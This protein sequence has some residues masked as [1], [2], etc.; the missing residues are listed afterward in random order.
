MLSEKY[1]EKKNEQELL[2]KIKS[3]LKKGPVPIAVDAV[4]NTKA[5]LRKPS[6]KIAIRRRWK[7]LAREEFE[8]SKFDTLRL[9]MPSPGSRQNG[10]D[11]E[12]DIV[13]PVYAPPRLENHEFTDNMM[14]IGLYMMLKQKKDDYYLMLLHSFK[15]DVRNFPEDMKLMLS[16]KYWKRNGMPKKGK[17]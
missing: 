5:D 11:L 8:K 13:V 16:G 7:K 2:L 6:I 3:E 15:L 12:E 17:K 1:Y 4:I 14:I 9:V 10:V